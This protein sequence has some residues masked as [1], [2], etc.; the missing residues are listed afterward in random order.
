MRKHEGVARLVAACS[1]CV[2][3]LLGSSYRF[4][5]GF[6]DKGSAFSGI[7]A[8]GQSVLSEVAKT[9]ESEKSAAPAAKTEPTASTASVSAAAQAAISDG[10]ALGKVIERYLSP[11]TA[12]TV[13]GKVYLKNST[14]LS[15]DIKSLLAEKLP[16][17]VKKN[18]TP[19]VLI[20]HTH[21]T[22]SFLHEDRDYYTANDAA[23]TLDENYNMVKLGNIV[24]DKLN[25]AGIK[26]LHDKTTHDYPSYNESYT[27][28]A[29]TIKSYLQKYPDIKIVIDMHR[30]S[31]SSGEADKVKPVIKVDGKKAAQIMLVMGSQSGNIKSFPKWRE[32]LKLAVRLQQQIETMYPGLARSLSLMSRL[33]NENLTTGSMLIEVG[34]EANSIDEVSYSAELIGNALVQT[35]QSLK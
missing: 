35:L 10:T 23:R 6:S 8:S 13:Y 25:A 34:T 20:V 9:G 17:T 7:P 33:Y 16:Y 19:Q 3:I 15:I 21:T 2:A 31:I 12:N 29:K 26:T 5:F 22:E 27:R 32:N 4:L 24:T 28:A 11:Y 30:D 18:S 1:C 14:D